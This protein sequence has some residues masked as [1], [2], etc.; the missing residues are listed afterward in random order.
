[1]SY[2]LNFVATLLRPETEAGEE[3]KYLQPSLL[4]WPEKR[5]AEACLYVDFFILLAKDI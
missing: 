1:M 2:V 4:I 5:E 3:K